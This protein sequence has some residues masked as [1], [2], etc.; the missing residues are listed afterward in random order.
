MLFRSL[1]GPE[2]RIG[3]F[4]L[5]FS[6]PVIVGSTVE[7]SAEVAEVVDGRIVCTL[8]VTVDGAGTAM[9]GRA[10]LIDFADRG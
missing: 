1:G 7:A 10:D 2:R 4:E 3:R 6:K 9:E 8:A 5:T